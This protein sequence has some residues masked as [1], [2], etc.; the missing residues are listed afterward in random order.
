MKVNNRLII[1]CL[2][3]LVKSIKTEL[4]DKENEGCVFAGCTC[5]NKN[6]YNNEFY[7]Y[8]DF[9]YRETVIKC[10]ED[11]ISTSGSGYSKL[12]NNQK[13]P[14]IFPKRMNIKANTTHPIAILDMAEMGLTNIPADQFA[15]LEITIVDF[16][17]N[18]I[19]A[20]DEAAFSR[21]VKLEVLDL[22]TNRL[23]EIKKATFTPIASTLVQLSLK[24]NELNQMD[25]TSLSSIL[26][27]LT[28][29]KL[30]YVDRNGF[31]KLPNLSKMKN[32]EDLS[33][34]YNQLESVN[35]AETDESLLPKS[36]KYLQMSNNRLKYITRKTFQNLVN[37]KYLYLS[38]NQ[39]SRIDSDAFTHLTRL[40]ALYLSRNYIKQIPSRAFYSLVNLQRLDLAAQNQILNKVDDYAFDRESNAVAIKKIDLSKNRIAILSNRAFCSRSKVHPYANV[41]EIDLTANQLGSISACIFR[42]MSK[43]YAEY[44]NNQYDL[45]GYIFVNHHHYDQKPVVNFKTVYENRLN[46]NLKCDCEIEKTSF[47]VNLEGE[48]ETSSGDL[49]KL[50][51]YRCNETDLLL[52]K[53]NVEAECLAIGEFSCPEILTIPP[54]NVI[55]SKDIRANAAVN[56]AHTPLFL[57]TVLASV[58]NKYLFQIKLFL[59]LIYLKML[60]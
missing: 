27:S 35:D 12:K 25:L 56:F 59:N 48:C 2:V 55:E 34:C 47:F 43:G 9:A 6:E 14:A 45:S 7:D 3:L 42:Q 15:N 38:S 54:N 52:S 5:G 17:N 51:D 39:I 32:L 13:E 26:T 4:N 46:Y 33:L 21:M 28:R 16:Y 8:E 23:S 60:I 44:D 24:T 1:L 37:L 10:K 58:V 30:L 11:D 53:K 57:I 50:K 18:S 36:L 22:S 40:S 31:T 20:I 19:F 49:I 29:L 41:K